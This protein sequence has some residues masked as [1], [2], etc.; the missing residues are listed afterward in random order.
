MARS[1]GTFP[2]WC[3]TQPMDVPGYWEDA[4]LILDGEG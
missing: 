1:A 3:V 2:K 4:V